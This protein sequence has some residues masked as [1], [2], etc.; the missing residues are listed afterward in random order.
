MAEGLSING[1]VRRALL[2]AAIAATAAPSVYNAQPWRLLLRP[3]R[4]EVHADRARLLYR[5]DSTGRQLHISCGCAV[6]NAMTAIAAQGLSPVVRT[7][8]RPDRPDLL[9]TIAPAAAAE[10]DPIGALHGWVALRNTP[11][12]RLESEEVDEHVARR[13]QRAA[14]AEGALLDV[15][16]AATRPTVVCLHERALR[17]EPRLGASPLPRVPPGETAAGAGLFVLSTAGDGPAAWLAA[18]RALQRVLLELTAGD[19]AGVPLMQIVECPAIR[20]ELAA[21]LPAGGSPQ[22][23][24]RAGR[25]TPQTPVRRR[26]LVDVLMHSPD[27]DSAWDQDTAP[28]GSSTSSAPSSR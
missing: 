18:G 11:R 9:A 26:H 27:W 15:I 4:L 1:A 17:T 22:I 16:D 13:L 20:S 12:S 7:L 8:P 10:S 28:T 21:L 3:D 5:L 14:R 6:F 19:L 25:A 23:V 2:E 24:L